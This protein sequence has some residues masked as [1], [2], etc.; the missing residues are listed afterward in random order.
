MLIDSLFGICN[1]TL[2]L[3]KRKTRVEEKG[4]TFEVTMIEMERS[5]YTIIRIQ[6]RV[7]DDAVSRTGGMYSRKSLLKGRT[8][9]QWCVRIGGEEVG[10][11]PAARGE[12]KL[13][14]GQGVQGAG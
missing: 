14:V 8:G 13:L 2:L 11:N 10:R 4:T 3:R 6:K 1:S 5:I 9:D 7:F 12:C